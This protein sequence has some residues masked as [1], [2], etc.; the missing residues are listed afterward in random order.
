MRSSRHA[1]ET[2]ERRGVRGAW[3]RAILA[4]IS[5][6]FSDPGFNFDSL[7]RAVGV[8]RRSIQGLFEETGKSFTEGLRFAGERQPETT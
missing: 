3:R 1:A 8:S 2:I 4:V 5:G 7:A 6:R